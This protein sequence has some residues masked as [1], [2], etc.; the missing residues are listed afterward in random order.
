MD[1]FIPPDFRDTVLS[2][3]SDDGQAWFD[4][5]PEILKQCAD[6]WQLTFEELFGELSISYVAKVNIGEKKLPGVLKICKVLG[7][8]LEAL[9]H[10]A[11]DIALQPLE[12]DRKLGAILMKRLT[13]GY[14]LTKIQLED[15]KK[16]T[17][18]AAPIIKNLPV[19][20]SE[21]FSFPSVI[22]WVDKD[23]VRLREK[24]A[25]FGAFSVSYVDKALE[26]AA[27]LELP[28]ADQR[29]MHGDLH[30]DNFL[31]D[32]EHGWLVIDPKGVIGDPAFNAAR[33]LWNPLEVLKGK[34][35]L[36][37]MVKKRVKILSSVTGI[38]SSR[39]AGWGYVDSMSFAC[40]TNDRASRDHTLACAKTLNKLYA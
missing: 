37:E 38:D 21:G 4:K 33:F 32:C 3:W 2:V 5:L 9:E 39:I 7:T 36:T 24:V 12:V 13:P 30:H 27:E 31:Y 15:D 34:K 19:A 14:T 6:K 11:A 23:L 28:K 29:L 17:E 35:G 10:F 40:W 22:D 18:I 26:I 20:V 25:A 1:F 8:E 16:A